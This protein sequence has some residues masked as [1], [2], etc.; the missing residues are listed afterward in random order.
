MSCLCVFICSFSWLA[1]PGSRILPSSEACEDILW[2]RSKPTG[3]K[4]CFRCSPSLSL[5]SAQGFVSIVMLKETL[6][7]TGL[8][9]SWTLVNF[10]NMQHVVAES[11]AACVRCWTTS[12]G[13]LQVH[14]TVPALRLH[15]SCTGAGR[16]MICLFWLQCH[17]QTTVRKN[18]L[19]VCLILW[20]QHSGRLALDPASSAAWGWKS[21]GLSLV[22]PFSGAD[23]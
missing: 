6:P 22:G 17:S 2:G 7:V 15:S 19:R 23:F 3:K 9:S 16:K 8:V 12:F 11:S 21:V 10:L 4:T 18:V 20:I 14:L 13:F 1:Q 5:S